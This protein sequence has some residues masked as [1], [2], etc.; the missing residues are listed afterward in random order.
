MK[1]IAPSPAAR[2]MNDLTP[3]DRPDTPEATLN[4]E[5]P[6]RPQ[7]GAPDDPQSDPGIEDRMTGGLP[8]H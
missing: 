5:Q 6:D 8:R 4:A 1:D 3:P 2:R 7:P